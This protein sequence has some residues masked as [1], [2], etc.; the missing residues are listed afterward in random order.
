[1]FNKDFSLKDEESIKQFFQNRKLEYYI[2]GFRYQNEELLY[3][4]PK[5][6]FGH[7]KIWHVLENIHRLQKLKLLDNE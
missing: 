2:N 3:V 4:I 6:I 1:M 5:S 7:R